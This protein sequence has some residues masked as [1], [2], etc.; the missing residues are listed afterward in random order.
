LTPPSPNDLEAI[1]GEKY[2][3]RFIN[4]EESFLDVKF[5]AK[6]IETADLV[7]IQQVKNNVTWLN[8]TDCMLRDDQLAYL[9]DFPNLTRLKIQ[10]NPMV[11]NKGIKALQALENLNQ[12]NLYG[13]RI[14]D[15]VFATL[16]Q[17]KSL[18]KLFL[19]NTR[20]TPT[21]IENFKSQHPEVEV[22]AGL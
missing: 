10:K 18:K 17:M 5:T 2:A 20:V 12:L 13:T 3:W 1:N 6:K 14:N 11:T 16:G 15:A 4:P 7:S 9:A 21:G 22:I 8:L 19:W